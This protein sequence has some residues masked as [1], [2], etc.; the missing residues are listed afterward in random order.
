MPILIQSNWFQ[1]WW[2]DRFK[3]N[4]DQNEK[5]K[6][7][8]DHTGYRETTSVGTSARAMLV[9]VDDPTWVDQA[10]SDTE[11]NRANAWLTGTMTTRS[12]EPKAAVGAACLLRMIGCILPS[13]R[14]EGGWKCG[15]N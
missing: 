11:R 2:G 1:E 13:Q 9:C 14:Q 12:A 3:L 4:V 10:A 15:P 5:G 6:F 7:E 8:N